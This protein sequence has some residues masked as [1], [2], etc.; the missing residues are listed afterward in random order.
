MVVLSTRNERAVE[1]SVC[2]QIQLSCLGGRSWYNWKW[3]C[4]CRWG[5]LLQLLVEAVSLVVSVH[6]RS[7]LDAFRVRFLLL[8]RIKMTPPIVASAKC[9]EEEKVYVA[10]RSSPL[11]NVGSAADN[12]FKDLHPSHEA[13]TCSAKP[14]NKSYLWMIKFWTWH[15]SLTTSLACHCHWWTINFWFSG[16]LVSVVFW[17]TS[18]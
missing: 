1:I 7:M 14:K 13:L 2:F 10:L 12:S 8:C 4:S 17:F 3:Q 15:L 18:C 6:Q 16:L 5:V 9:K 11:V